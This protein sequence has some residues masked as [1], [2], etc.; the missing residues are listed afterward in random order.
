M[1]LHGNV[2]GS[3]HM[4]GRKPVFEAKTENDLVDVIKDLSK[5]GVSIRN[6]GSPINCIQLC[7]ATCMVLMA[8]LLRTNLAGYEWLKSFRNYC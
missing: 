7:T 5:S 2:S 6:Q 4:S 1:R 3:S 8:S